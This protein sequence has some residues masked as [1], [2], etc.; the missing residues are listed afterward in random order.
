MSVYTCD[1]EPEKTHECEEGVTLNPCTDGFNPYAVPP[2]YG[3]SGDGD[4]AHIAAARAAS[5]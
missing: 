5:P 3:K 2:C 4:L 1:R